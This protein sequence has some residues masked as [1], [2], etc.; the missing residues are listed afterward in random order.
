MCVYVR[1]VCACVGHVRVCTCVYVHTYV[2]GGGQRSALWAPGMEAEEGPEGLAESEASGRSR[3]KGVESIELLPK[4][5]QVSDSC[6]GRGAGRG[7]RPVGPCRRRRPGTTFPR[8]PRGQATL[9]SWY[10][11]RPIGPSPQPQGAGL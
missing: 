2:G 6:R 5:G 1:G 8:P 9:L 11:H 3:W 4:R 10:R 7:G